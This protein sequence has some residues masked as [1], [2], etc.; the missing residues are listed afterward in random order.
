MKNL[1]EKRVFSFAFLLNCINI[2]DSRSWHNGRSRRI[3]ESKQIRGREDF[4]RRARDFGQVQSC[5]PYNWW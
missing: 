2:N 3:I 5:C 1:I 4:P